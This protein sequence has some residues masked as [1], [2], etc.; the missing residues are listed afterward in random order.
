M[1]C[2]N[3]DFAKATSRRSV[4]QKLS[5]FRPSIVK[6]FRYFVEYFVRA[7]SGT[8]YSRADVSPCSVAPTA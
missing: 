3:H 5:L 7:M 4:Y 1:N 8:C 2:I 6:E